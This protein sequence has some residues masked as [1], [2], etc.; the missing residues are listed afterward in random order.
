[1][2][3]A[4]VLLPSLVRADENDQI[5]FLHLK[6][7]DGAVSLVESAVK[8]GRLKSSH[9]PE[10]QGELHLELI[11]TN[12]ASLWSG[13]LADPLTRRY[14]YEDPASPGALKLKTVQLTEAEFTV[15]VPFHKDAA[16]LRVFSLAKPASRKEA[17]AAPAAAK[18]WSGI[19]VLPAT[20]AAP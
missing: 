14:E 1:L 3:L 9:D 20:G 7:K 4:V 15:R 11:A 5:L 17:L 8:P 6:L 18:K 2:L 13:V 16:H 19:V 12:G 10:K